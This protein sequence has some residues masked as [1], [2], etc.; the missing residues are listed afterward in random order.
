[1]LTLDLHQNVSL[2]DVVAKLVDVVRTDGNRSKNV[3][4]R[5]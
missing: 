1:M 5:H 3:F 2:V 4:L